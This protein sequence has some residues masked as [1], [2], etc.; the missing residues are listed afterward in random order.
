MTTTDADPPTAL[1]ARTIVDAN[2]YMTL[3]TADG[4][5]VPWASPVWFAHRVFR[6]FVWVSRPGARHSRNIS[7]RR[8][9]GIVVFDS[10]VAV[11]EGRAVYLEAV[12]SEVHDDRA[13]AWLTVFSDRSIA[14]GA[15]QWGIDRVTGDSPFRLYVATVSA[16]Y[17]LDDH[18]QRVA[19]DLTQP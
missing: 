8:D 3:A 18:D 10:T 6:E 11:G 16:S 15:A 5:G 17:V 4:A 19:V 13:E 12:A 14:Q 9:V 1:D 2:A 7:V